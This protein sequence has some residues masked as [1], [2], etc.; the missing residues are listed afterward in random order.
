MDSDQ[1]LK[2]DERTLAVENAGYGWALNFIL[3][4]LLIDIAFRGF[5]MKEAAWDLMGL[6]IATGLICPIYKFRNKSQGLPSRK[7]ML[8]RF[9][10]V[11]V[12][13]AVAALIAA[14]QLARVLAN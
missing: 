2:R 6:V 14:T 1:K 3:F 10:G 13:V 8:F 5:F 9:A 11:L 4:A 7:T 12:A